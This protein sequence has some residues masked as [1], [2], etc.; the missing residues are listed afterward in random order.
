MWLLLL[1]QQLYNITQCHPVILWYYNRVIFVYIIIHSVF[2]T[3]WGG[4]SAPKVTPK[5]IV[6]HLIELTHLSVC[7]HMAL[8][9]CMPI[10]TYIHLSTAPN[11]Y[12]R[13]SHRIMEV[14]ICMMKTKGILSPPFCHHLAVNT[15]CAL[16][17]QVKVHR[18]YYK[19]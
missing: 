7:T 12:K 16:P 5:S 9:Q 17:E 15:L 14:W 2:C 3:P 4:A 19:H 6:T 18:E 8:I 13:Y 1:L 10:H 11:R